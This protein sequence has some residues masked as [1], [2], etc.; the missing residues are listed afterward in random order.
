MAI[1]NLSLSRSYAQQSKLLRRGL[2]AQL[3]A[4]KQIN[5][6][7]QQTDLLLS[8]LLGSFKR[9]AGNQQTAYDSGSV[10]SSST[11]TSNQWERVVDRAIN[12]VLGKSPGKGANNF[13]NALDTAFPSKG[14]G[15]ST[16][17]LSIGAENYSTNG[18]LAEISTEQAILYRQ[19]STNMT[20]ALKVLAGIQYFSPKADKESV[21]ALRELIR[22]RINFL[23]EEFRRADEPRSDLVESYLRSLDEYTTE[24]GK[25]AYLNDPRLAVTIEDEEQTTNFKLF[26]SYIETLSEAWARYYNAGKFGRLDSLSV[27]VDRAR[28]LLPIVSQANLDFSNALESVG[29]SENERRSRASLFTALD[30]P[31]IL[32]FPVTPSKDKSGGNQN[33][34]QIDISRRFLEIVVGNN[35]NTS[36]GKSKLTGEIKVIT[37]DPAYL[38]TWLP[39]ITVSDLID[40]LDRYSNI[41]A[42]SALES[43]YGID[44]VTDQADRLFWTIAPVVA[45]LKTIVA[46]DSSSQSMLKQILS[47]E[48]VT[49]ALDNILS[50]LNALA[51]LAA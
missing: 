23:V 11:N 40:W 47:N 7:G 34:I 33:S 30:L 2:M 20:D 32:E 37:P 41:E 31:A 24:F 46:A 26:K 21:E 8:D 15:R 49:W 22:G 35:S 50:Q 28:V 51:E 5:P 13:V 6:I 17:T 48:R 42:P 19:V 29:L 38:S 44:F 1:N 27:K 18:L 43:T 9:Y 4:T 45:N 10:Q 14:Y 12:Q 3:Y 36:T 39:K 25:Q 16:T